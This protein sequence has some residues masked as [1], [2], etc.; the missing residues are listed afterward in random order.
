[1]EVLKIQEEK[2]TLTVLVDGDIKLSFFT[3]KYKLLNKLIDEENLRLASVEDIGCMKFS[4]ITG[5]A[6]NKDYIDLYYILQNIK[7]EDLLKKAKEKFSD[8]DENLILKSLVYF[9]DIDIEPIIFKNDNYVDFKDV[10]SFLK[11]EV[12]IFIKKIVFKKRNESESKM[13]KV[14]NVIDVV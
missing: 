4:A 8:L 6:T 12:N 3:Y 10:A 9:D 7:L 14:S 1:M 13:I 5:R 11:K 2:N